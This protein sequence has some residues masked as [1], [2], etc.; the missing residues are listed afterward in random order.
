MKLNTKKDALL[1]SSVDN[2]MEDLK[3]KE[4]ISRYRDLLIVLADALDMAAK[5]ED[6]FVTLGS[7]RKRDA[8]VLTITYQGDKTFVPGVNLQALADLCSNLL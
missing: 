4:G 7:T 3:S 2:L 6:I 8:L 1:P 5:G